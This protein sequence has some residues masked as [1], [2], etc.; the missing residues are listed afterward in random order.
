MKK[1]YNIQ[2]PNQDQNIIETEHNTLFIEEIPTIYEPVSVSSPDGDEIPGMY[3]AIE[4]YTLYKLFLGDFMEQNTGN[5]KIIHTLQKGNFN[6]LVE[7][8][9]SSQGGDTLEL[10]ELY[11]ILNSKYNG[12]VTT[13]LN[14]GYSAGALAFLFGQERI[15]YEHSDFMIHSYSAGLGGKREDL[16][17]Q[18]VHQDIQITKFFEKILGEYF[19]K[20]ELQKI[21]DGKDYWLNSIEMLERGIATAIIIDGEYYTKDEYLEKINP[22]PK[23][24]KKPKKSKKKTDNK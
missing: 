7:L 5:H 3:Q 15:V 8:H 10:M 14:Y 13:Y 6:D 9:I 20:E 21:N 24:T 17:N 11:N 12:I 23:K 18:M 1:E 2:E 19:T 4:G 22:V 16:L